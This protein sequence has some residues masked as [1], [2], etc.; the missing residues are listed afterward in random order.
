ML[1]LLLLLLLVPL[2]LVQVQQQA[3]QQLEAG[4]ACQTLQRCWEGAVLAAWAA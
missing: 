1:T 3:A 2:Q 4:A